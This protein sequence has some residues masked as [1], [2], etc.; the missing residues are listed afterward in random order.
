MNLKESKKGYMRELKK[1]KKERER[2][3][4]IHYNTPPL[5]KGRRRKTLP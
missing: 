4:A 3:E 5:N 1:K 2:N